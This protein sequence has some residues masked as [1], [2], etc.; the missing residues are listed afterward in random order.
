M[1]RWV[2]YSTVRGPVA[3]PRVTT[4]GTASGHY[5]SMCLQLFSIPWV[6]DET[7]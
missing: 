1:C 3:S 2:R 6:G 5:V 4:C 7:M